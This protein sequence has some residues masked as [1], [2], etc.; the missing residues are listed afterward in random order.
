MKS[1]FCSISGLCFAVS[2]YLLVYVVFHDF[3]MQEAM[4]QANKEAAVVLAVLNLIVGTLAFKC[5]ISSANKEKPS[6]EKDNS[7]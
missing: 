2:V 4:P 5:A 3:V 6:M 1:I 7:T